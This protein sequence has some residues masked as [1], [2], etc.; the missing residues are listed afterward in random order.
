[1][2]LT[3]LVTAEAATETRLPKP[4]DRW[5]QVRT[6]NFTIFSNSNERQ[7]RQAGNNL[8][9]LRAV[10]RNLFGGMVFSSPV[11]TY[12][13]VFDHP[14]TFAP[15]TLYYEGREKQLA[16]YFSPGRLANQVAIVAN[17]YGSEVSS[18]IFHEYV[19]YV[20][21]T[22]QAEL[23]LW[24]N[25]GLAEFYSTFELN[26][27]LA[28]IGYPIGNHLLWL[29]KNPIIPLT[30]FLSID[31]DSPDYNEGNRRGVFYAQSWALTHMLVMG[32]TDGRNRATAYANLL[33][34]GV[35]Q[36]EAFQQAIGGT[37][38]EIEKDLNRYARSR[39]FS[40]SEIPV[41]AQVNGAS[42]L[43][44]MSYP[45]VLTRLGS[46]LIALGPD[47]AAFAK[48]HFDTALEV[49]GDFGP[50]V[51][52]LGRLDEAAGRRNDAL[53]R[54]ERAAELAPDDFMVNFLLGKA[55]FERHEEAGSAEK[56]ESLT[57]RTRAALRKAAV[58]RPSFAEAWALLGT[59]YTWD[60]EPDDLGIKAMAMAHHLLP[61][62]GDIGYNL[63]LLYVRRD[64]LDEARQTI[65]RMR[66]AGVDELLT[67]GAES[68][69]DNR[70]LTQARVRLRSQ[71]NS[72]KGV[73][74]DSTAD[75]ELQ[76]FPGSAERR[77]FTQ[78]YN[79]A[80]SLI[81]AGDTVQAIAQLEVLVR[82]SSS[83]E[84][85]AS[86][87]ALLDQTRSYLEFQAK[88]EEAQRLANSGKIEAA[89]EILEPLLEE[90]AEEI[91]ADQ[92]SDFLAKLYGY[93]DFQDRYN[94]AVDLVN[95]GDF[96]AAIQI[97]EPL[98]ADAPSP[99]LI[100]MADRLLK[101]LQ[102]MR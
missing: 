28:R 3:S 29:Q 12:I 35:D 74:S 30:D 88:A 59:T 50:S 70:E 75:G 82:E 64:R 9:E 89:I 15:Y 19:H 17:R 5:I 14:K 37:Y 79:E 27:D 2:L 84:H 8:E 47:R 33:K 101:D 54:Y 78:K 65:D 52:G 83:A 43:T 49:D 94:R 10:L 36:D 53:S 99:Q 68:M 85:A 23:P 13:F 38:K 80:V 16:G 91:Q 51:A 77:A 20:L 40:Y 62:R 32:S 86:A 18:T 48:E 102:K 45:E 67:N 21:N 90:A 87:Q 76:T 41:D 57:E 39:K 73:E 61:K 63:T 58:L 93:R 97:L 72:E 55:L 66:V 92:I 98:V 26:G 11:P 100:A 24:M 22:N 60:L 4:K 44:E 95:A 42:T 46:L 69:I 31:Y 6:P 81:N 7:T 34:Q 96:D 56:V 1:M 25:E 71:Q